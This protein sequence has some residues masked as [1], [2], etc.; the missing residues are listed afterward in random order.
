MVLSF[1]TATLT[2]QPVVCSEGRMQVCV[3]LSK[4]HLGSMA[5]LKTAGPCAARPGCLEGWYSVPLFHCRLENPSLGSV[6]GATQCNIPNLPISVVS[7]PVGF[8]VHPLDLAHYCLNP[9]FQGKHVSPGISSTRTT[10]LAR[11]IFTRG[12]R[13]ARSHGMGVLGN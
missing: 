2:H 4:Q 8:G 6:P 7:M 9:L 3:N 10:G 5:C 13:E 1:W 11:F 12:G